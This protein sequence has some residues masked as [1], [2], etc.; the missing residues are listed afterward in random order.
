MFS[1]LKFQHIVTLA[2]LSCLILQVIR[3][4]HASELV[5]SEGFPFHTVA[6][7][8][9]DWSSLHGLKLLFSLW[10]CILDISL[11]RDAYRVI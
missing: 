8:F 1:K 2:I 4:D 10:V 3:K 6:G 9:S 7:F 11:K 5:M